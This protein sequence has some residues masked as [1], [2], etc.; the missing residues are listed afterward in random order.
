[1]LTLKRVQG[2]VVQGDRRTQ[3]PRLK[4]GVFVKEDSRREAG[5][6]S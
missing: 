5:D 1:M 6:K 4:T 2:D 3:K